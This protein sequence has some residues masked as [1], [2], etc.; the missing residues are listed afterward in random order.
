MNQVPERWSE[1]VLV[2]DMWLDSAQ[3]PREAGEADPVGERA[4]CQRFLRDYR[5]TIELK[6]P[7]SGR[8]ATGG[9]IG[10][11]LDAQSAGVAAPSGRSGAGLAQLDQPGRARRQDLRPAGLGVRHRATR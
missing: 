11:A 1:S 3:D 4:T 7:G 8:A 9:T 5:L 6:C 2:P 10:P